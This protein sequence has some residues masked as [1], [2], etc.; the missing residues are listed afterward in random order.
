[1]ATADQVFIFDLLALPAAEA[2]AS[3]DAVRFSGLLDAC[4]TLVLASP[5]P[6]KLGCGIA[7]D[8]RQLAA[9]F[10]SMRCFAQVAGVVEIRWAATAL[11]CAIV[12]AVAAV[13]CS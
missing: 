11:D 1:M 13:S 8:L 5:H 3:A 12:P 7:G 10:P 9:A 2:A 4:L 6:L